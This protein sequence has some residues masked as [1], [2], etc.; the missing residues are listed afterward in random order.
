MSPSRSIHPGT[1]CARTLG[2]AAL[3]F[4]ASAGAFREGVTPQGR[5]FVS[6][7]VADTELAALQARQHEFSLWI[8]TAARK[9]GAYLADAHVSIVDA[10]QHVVF[11]APLEGPWLMVDLPL[12]HY[13]IEARLDG[14][15]QRRSTTIH[16]GDHHQAIFYFD[17]DADVLTAPAAGA[18]AAPR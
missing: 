17:V 2:I 16:A 5:H 13:T 10:R 9:S 3:A 18:S 7:G 12:G 11:D 6:G 4:C 15:S 8:V 1:L 14:Q